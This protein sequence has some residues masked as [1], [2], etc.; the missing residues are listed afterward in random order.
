M[1]FLIENKL[2]TNEWPFHYVDSLQNLGSKVYLGPEEFRTLFSEISR[3]LYPHFQLPEQKVLQFISS[4]SA[5][6]NQILT[7]V[8]PNVALTAIV[9]QQ[10]LKVLQK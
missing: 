1:Q 4:N 7:M 9:E 8:T 6:L 2:F 3:K 5:S 10:F